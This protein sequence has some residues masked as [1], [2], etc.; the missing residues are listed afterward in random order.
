MSRAGGPA[1]LDVRIES[2]SYRSASGGRLDVLRDLKFALGL[3]HRERGT[4][5]GHLEDLVEDRWI[6]ADQARIPGYL[7]R[8]QRAADGWGYRLDVDP[9][10]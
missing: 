3:Y 4:Y 5:P 9:A 7:V 6:S 8:Y 10:R 2:K 1:Q